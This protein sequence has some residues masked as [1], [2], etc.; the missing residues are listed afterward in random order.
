M[1]IETSSAVRLFFPNPSLTLVY[2]ESIVN[3]L[4]AGATDIKITISI[5][6]FTTPE[7][8]NISVEDNGGGFTD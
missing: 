1:E 6:S 3:A 8:L 5:R 7:T 4:D 2:F